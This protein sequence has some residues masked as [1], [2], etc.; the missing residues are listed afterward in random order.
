MRS[1]SGEEGED[2]E[3]GGGEGA[4]DSC[5]AMHADEGQGQV[6]ISWSVGNPQRL[7]RL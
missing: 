6:V 2:G 7:D 1:H 3:T 5:H 4:G